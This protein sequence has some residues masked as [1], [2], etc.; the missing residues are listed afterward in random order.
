MLRGKH[1]RLDIMDVTEQ[2]RFYAETCQAILLNN[3]EQEFPHMEADS[4][5]PRGNWSREIASWFAPT[6]F[7]EPRFKERRNVLDT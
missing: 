2:Q 3:V 6:M 5:T 7:K 4:I 1:S